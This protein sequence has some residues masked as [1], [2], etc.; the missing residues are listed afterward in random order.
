[1][2]KLV[3]VIIPS[4]NCEATIE[5]T[6]ESIQDQDYSNIEIIVIDD[7][8]SDNTKDLLLKN[9][10]DKITY[11]YQ[12]NIG[13]AGARNKGL[14]LANGDYITFV[15]ADDKIDRRFVSMCVNILDSNLEIQ[16]TYPLFKYFGRSSKKGNLPVLTIENFLRLNCIPIYVMIRANLLQEIGGFDTSINFAED[17]ECWIRAIQ[18]G[19]GI[20]SVHRVDEYLYNYRLRDT[21]DSLTDLYRMT[22]KW[23]D[24]FIY[25]YN[26]HYDF[27]KQN[28]YSIFELMSDKIYRKKY[29]DI[30]YKKLLYRLFNRKKYIKLYS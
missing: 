11:F 6:L 23:D 4:F 14:E 19:G 22:S 15:D 21:N 29:Y 28:G 25:I 27:F 13:A 18:K 30:W 5:E 10:V 26:K 9:W 16:I 24:S 12:E 17:W 7:G 20:H 2:S 1:M 8:S 3:S